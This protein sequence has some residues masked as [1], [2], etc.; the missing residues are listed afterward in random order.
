MVGS[1]DLIE[2]SEKWENHP[3]QGGLFPAL[4]DV[5]ESTDLILDLNSKLE[6]LQDL[7]GRFSLT[8]REIEQGIK[9]KRR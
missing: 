5:E 1:V 4:T 8:L 7:C 6:E 2:G 9:A 3:K